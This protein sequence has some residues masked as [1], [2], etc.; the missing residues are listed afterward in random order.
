MFTIKIPATSANLGP[1][2]DS[3]GLSLQLYNKFTFKRLKS[4]DIRI[5]IKEVDTGN[6]I[7][8][9]IKDN[10]IYRAMMYLFE[11]YDVRPEGI[12]L[13]EEVAIPFARGLG[14]SATAILGGLFG[15]NIMLGE[16]LEDEELLKIAV[17]L[18]KHPD[19]VVPALKGGFVINVLKGSDLYYKKIN[20]GEQLRVILCIPEFQLKTED[21]RQ[22]LPRQIEF[23]DAVFNHSRTAFLTSCFYERDW[24]SLRVAMQD[25]LHQD[26]RSSLIPGFD[27]VVKSAY[28]NGAVGVALSGAGPT[29]ISF[30]KDKGDKIGE[31]MVKAFGHYNIN[32]KYIETGLDN[33]GLILKGHKFSLSGGSR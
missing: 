19:N 20:P 7:E 9:P 33:K 6:I 24:E 8:L 5:K 22:V 3:L 12:E 13:M 10:L 2:F 29:V 14:S 17:K 27:E 15:A 26:Y 1:G 23:K 21:L 30:A 18:E 28:D 11:R 25:R 4:S 16:P 32:S 31:A